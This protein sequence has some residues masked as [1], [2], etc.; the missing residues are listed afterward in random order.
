MQEK[1][2][3]MVLM[4]NNFILSLIGLLKPI[5]IK[6]KSTLDEI[7]LKEINLPAVSVDGASVFMLERFVNTQ[8]ERTFGYSKIQ[9]IRAIKKAISAMVVINKSYV[10]NYQKKA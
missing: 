8:Y 5:S 6:P 7:R 10:D 4:K 1:N 2:G 3:W 9:Q